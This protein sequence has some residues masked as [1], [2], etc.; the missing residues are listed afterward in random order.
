[1]RPFL[2]LPRAR[3]RRTARFG[4]DRLLL[5][6]VVLAT[7]A[8]VRAQMAPV[9]P[10]NTFNRAQVCDQYR[11]Y[12]LPSGHVLPLWNGNVAAG[13]PGALDL[14]YLKATLRR[15]NYF[16]SMDGLPGNIVFDPVT[17]ARCQQAALMMAH[18]HAI[19]HT[20]PSSWKFYSRVV[21]LT[22]LHSDLCLDWH[23]DQGPGAIDRY[24]DDPGEHNACV[25]HRR[26]LL[27]P[28]STV[29]GTGVIP[30]RASAHPGVNVTW[31][32]AGLPPRFTEVSAD[33]AVSRLPSAPA[34]SW[35]PPGF[36]PARFVFARWSFS[37]TNA[38][39]KHA[40]VQVSKAGR[41]LAVTQSRVEYQSAPDGGGT[42][43]GANT[44]VWT[45]PGNC[46][47]P[48]CD[49]TYRVRISDVRV[50]GRSRDFAY[51]VTSIDPLRRDRLD[52]PPA[53]DGERLASDSARIP[54]TRPACSA[55]ALR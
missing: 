8:S 16:R 46:V 2:P 5:A 47:C 52:A 3:L 39:F 42:Y 18:A 48:T 20:P 24:M 41:P 10:V 32:S 33:L 23:G 27:C 4:R 19:S 31:V 13:S 54:G 26:W 22:A 7:G 15:I 37:L 29:M 44:L 34:A 30:A 21:A 38:D 6:A 9:P 12:Y 50:A 14:A 1:M 51:T 53:Q 55:G 36:V 49:E 43:L 35:P 40:T 45:L 17:N 28:G 11:D 25:G